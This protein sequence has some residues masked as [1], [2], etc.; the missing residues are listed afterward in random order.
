MQKSIRKCYLKLTV[1]LLILFSLTVTFLMSCYGLIP[2][3]FLPFLGAL[4]G[5]FV[6]TMLVGLWL[7]QRAS[8]PLSDQMVGS[9]KRI[10]SRLSLIE[11][12]DYNV[13]IDYPQQDEIAPVVNT[14]D[15][16]GKEEQ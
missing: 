7:I 14:I 16:E 13:Y 9:I 8:N 4:L 2:G 1:A 6:I 12:G 3:S 10:T 5:G 15:V 11:K